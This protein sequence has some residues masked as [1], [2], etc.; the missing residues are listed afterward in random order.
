MKYISNIGEYIA[1][2]A[3]TF[4]DDGSKSGIAILAKTHQEA[5]TIAKE[6]YRKNY[7]NRLLTI[8]VGMT[9]ILVGDGYA[10]D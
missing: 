3:S 9:P 5:D 6:F 8:T 1:F 2:Y 4:F 7:P 10:T